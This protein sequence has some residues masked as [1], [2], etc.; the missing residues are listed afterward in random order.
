MNGGSLF[1]EGGRLSEPL[2]DV[3]ERVPA[4][5][6][7]VLRAWRADEAAQSLIR[8]VDARVGQGVAVYPA[9]VL[10]AL[11]LTPLSRVNVLILGQDPYHGP[12]QA[13]GLAFSVP[14]GVRTPPS[15]RNIFAELQRD[16][17]V[18]RHSND[19]SGWAR[20]GVLLLNTSL[21]VEEGQPASHARRGWEAL[22]GALVQAVAER[23][24][25]CVYLLWGG[26]A[27]QFEGLIREHSPDGA[28]PLILKANHPSPLSARRPPLP[29]IGCGHFSQAAAHLARSGEAI[30]WSA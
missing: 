14:R 26:H 6:A 2:T 20:Q 25:S 13:H 21:T 1:P 3:L 23:P 15:L 11:E 30:D 18:T 10:R 8:H 29:F 28:D 7:P 19:L 16:L 22:T 4:E 17:G 27:Q 5:W 12:G 24:R 9:Q